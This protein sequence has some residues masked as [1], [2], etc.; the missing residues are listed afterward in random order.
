MLIYMDESGFTGEDLLHPEQP[1]FVHVSTCLSDEECAA[2]AK[3][4]F[5]GVQGN[6]LKHKNL[7]RRP[8]GQRRIVDFVKAVRGTDKFTIWLCHKEFLLLTYL[9]DLLVEPCMYKHGMDLYKDGG[10]LAL[11]NMTYYC[12]KTFQS[13]RFLRRH[14]ER[15]QRMMRYRTLKNYRT[16]FAM[17]HRDYL[18]TDK[19]TQ[20]ILVF[21]LGAG[22]ELGFDLLRRTPARA[23]DPAL[24]TTVSTCEH[25]RKRTD[26][27]IRLIHDRS[28]NLSKDKWL[29]DWIA[30]PEIEKVVLGIP[31]REV[32]YPLNVTET[33]FADSRSHLQL[34]FCDLV[35]GA[36]AEWARHYMDLP[37]DESY[38]SRLEENGIKELNLSTIWPALEVDPEALGMKGWSGEHIEFLTKQFAEMD[39]RRARD[40]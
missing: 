25:W 36:S 17:L 14:L 19:R 9:V 38:V 4:H 13:D 2:L 29:W 33:E 8:T 22:M 16:F 1:V 27:P 28:S 23:L 32:V 35:A 18:R 34:Q 5:S 26:A 39:K 21:Y 10:S 37:N 24:T 15:F 12:L 6:E 31:G 20:D 30:S 7:S 3:D 11:S 40:R